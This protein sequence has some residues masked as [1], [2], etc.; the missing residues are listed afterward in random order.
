MTTG[1]L[2]WV[3]NLHIVS[4]EVDDAG[5][6]P[7]FLGYRL[8]EL[9]LIVVRIVGMGSPGHNEPGVVAVGDE[10][11]M[12]GRDE[13][14]H[15]ALRFVESAPEELVPFRQSVEELVDARY[16]VFRDEGGDDFFGHRFRQDGVS[17][18]GGHLTGCDNKKRATSE[19]FSHSL[20]NVL[21]STEREPGRHVNAPGLTATAA[22]EGRVVHNRR[23]GCSRA[24]HVLARLAG[25]GVRHGQGE[26]EV[27]G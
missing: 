16:F 20:G 3:G 9:D 15:R 27:R 12:L 23:R 4:R 10:S 21:S 11:R 13:V 2:R 5:L 25:G 1:A 18:E 14:G 24:V 7:P 6:P 19:Y 17:V 8:E 22:R 26:T